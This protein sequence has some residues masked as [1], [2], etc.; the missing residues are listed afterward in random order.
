MTFVGNVQKIM[1]DF[2]NQRAAFIEKRDNP[3]PNERFSNPEIV[4]AINAENARE[5][6]AQ[7]DQLSI[8]SR[9]QIQFEIDRYLATLKSR[10][11][12]T[13]ATVDATDLALLNGV[14]ALTKQDIEAM[15]E[16]H[17]GN[18]A[19]Q[20][21]VIDYSRENGLDVDVVFYNQATREEAARSYAVG[22]MQC[23]QNPD[24]LQWA[25]YVEGRAVPPSLQGE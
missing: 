7:I 6:N 21:I 2:E 3:A 15:F 13:P 24:S 20:Q 19:M 9:A 5:I 1:R 16:R 11:T 25:L 23:L 8:D 10:Y 12:K 17:A 14:V 4:A 18:P 22:A